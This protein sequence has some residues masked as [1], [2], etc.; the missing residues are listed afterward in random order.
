MEAVVS[1]YMR[2]I[3]L[4]GGPEF[5]SWESRGFRIVKECIQKLAESLVY[6]VVQQSTQKVTRADA[7]RWYVFCR[8]IRY[9]QMP[10]NRY[11]SSVE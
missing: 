7:E 10:I 5:K 9:N 1:S 6:D 8:Q 4:E 2:A 11:F 3:R